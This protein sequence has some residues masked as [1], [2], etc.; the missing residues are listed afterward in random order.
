VK[1]E[2]RTEQCPA[3]TGAVGDRRVDILHCGDP[4]LYQTELGDSQSAS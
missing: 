4:T 1:V 2:K 3:Q